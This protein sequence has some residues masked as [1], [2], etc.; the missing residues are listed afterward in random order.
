MP[1]NLLSVWGTV[2]SIALAVLILLVMITVHEFGHYAMGKL[3]GFRIDEFSIGFGPALFKKRRKRS[4]ELF[5]LRLIPLGGYCA[6]HGEDGLEPPDPFI[7]APVPPSENGPDPSAQVLSD[8]GEALPAKETPIPSEETNEG[9]K[10]ENRAPM[11]APS[12]EKCEGA[13]TEMACWKRILV[14]V[15]GACMN[16]LLALFLI[17]VCFFSFGQSYL[18]VTAPDG[19]EAAEFSFQEG[20][21]LLG[22]GGRN[23]YLSSD[24]GL[25]VN[26]M[27]AG[28]EVEFR[29]ARVQEDGSYREEKISIRLRRDVTLKNSTDNSALAAIGVGT[30][31]EGE[32]RYYCIESTRYRLGF[33]PTLGHSFAYSYKIAGSILRVL[34][35]LFTG[36]LGLRAFGGP[37]TTITTTASIASQGF[38]SFLEIAALIGVNLAVFNLLPVPAL[39][40]CKVVFTVIEWIRGKPVSRKVEAIIHTVGFFFLIG[41]AILVDILQF[42]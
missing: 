38:A 42:V 5:A 8:S 32:A 34:G 10:T 30:E 18:R 12:P 6:F 7:D 9:T 26:G 22:G 36:K 33:F 27:K 37:V 39:D 35:E 25:A 31:Q 1:S 16:Y 19:Q 20:D 11:S 17:L 2:G 24:I 3:L 14:L 15:A 4:G 29:V 23:F 40:G 21:I 28:D 41:F 13:F